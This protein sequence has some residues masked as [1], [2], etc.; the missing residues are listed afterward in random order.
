MVGVHPGP[1]FPC[2]Q[3]FCSKAAPRRETQSSLPSFSDK[4]QTISSPPR[5]LMPKIWPLAMDGALSPPPSPFIFQASGGPSLGPSFSRPVSFEMLLRS[6][7][8]HCGQSL[9][10][11]ERRRI[12]VEP[13][14]P[15]RGFAFILC[16]L[17]IQALFSRKIEH[18]GSRNNLEVSIPALTQ[19]NAFVRFSS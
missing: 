9:A 5:L 12:N 11:A 18:F 17:A 8:C 10:D 1:S 15:S 4:A 19:V 13:R 14:H 3:P 2:G 16:G 6:D 7:P